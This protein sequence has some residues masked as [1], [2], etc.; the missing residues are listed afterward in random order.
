MLVEDISLE[1]RDALLSRFVAFLKGGNELS[2]RSGPAA[3][4][5]R[6]VWTI[7]GLNG[8]DFATRLATFLQLPTIAFSGLSMAVPLID[9]FAPR[10]LKEFS[11]YPFINASGEVSIAVAE[12]PD[13]AFR[14]AARIVLEREPS[15]VI[16]SYEDIASA[17]AS[18]LQ[19][20][21][22]PL[23]EADRDAGIS[24]DDVDNLRDLAS[25]APV[26]RA[27]SDLCERAVEWRA[28]DL[29]IEPMRDSLSVRLRIDGVLRSV[30]APPAHMAAALISRIKILA[31]LNIAE[32]RIPQDGA[33]RIKVGGSQID[34]RVA[35]LP[36]QH[37]ES[38][39][40][41]F[42]PVDRGLLDLAR[43]GLSAQS[44]QTLKRLLQSRNGMI[45]ISGPTGSGKT[46]TLAGA[47][48]HLN[49]ASRK[50]VTVE[51][52][53][54]YELQ[55]ITQSQINP[56][57]G[58]T[59]A[60]ALRSF[61]RFDPNVIMVGEIRDSETAQIAVQAALTG[62]LLLTTL[63]TETAA[64]VVPRL[65]DLGVEDFLLQSTLRAVIAQ[66]L[67]RSLCEHCR[68]S[69]ELS[70]LRFD[71]E[72][73]YAAVGLSVGEFV[74]EPVGCDRC[75]ETGYRGRSG[76]FEVLEVTPDV[77][78]LIRRGVDGPGL[79]A[80]ARAR[81]FLTM[82]DDARAQIRAGRTTAA[83]ALRVIPVR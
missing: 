45:I 28:T 35:I 21:D 80:H 19:S 18:R 67:L 76:V 51:D 3:S 8:S 83:E 22:V 24:Q 20:E 37:G 9:R 58:L 61:L 1:T 26:V 10:F 75:G 39:V 49:D 78:P 60:T 56:A 16:A 7:S 79:D 32:R 33:A 70:Q 63:H 34:V 43:L 74:C 2:F 25:G 40:L 17:L 38:A 82:M 41:R 81:G 52:P 14:Q 54:E 72:P 55:G 44:E 47:L 68:K 69:Q 29:H 23:G 57:V 66:R 71:D 12:P 36:T 27:I 42:L 48:T 53:I 13:A 77:R 64:A 73:Q 4:T 62:H 6:E 15:Y 11:A 59:F 50:I 5:F 31:G 30:P 65:I 46:T